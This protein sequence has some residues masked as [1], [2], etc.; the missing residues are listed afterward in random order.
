VK[1]PGLLRQWRSSDL[2]EPEVPRSANGSTAIERWRALPRAQRPPWPDRAE[3]DKVMRLLDSVPPIV[4]PAE[5]DLLR[6]QLGLVAEGRALVVRGGDRTESFATNTEA[7][8]VANAGALAQLA[9]PLAH[10]G[11]GPVV[12]VARVAGLYARSVASAVDPVGLPAYRGDLIN[13]AEPT[14]AARVADPHRMIQAYAHASG[15]TNIL[16]VHLATGLANPYALQRKSNELLDAMD[17]GW[18]YEETAMEIN[19]AMIF[20]QAYGISTEK[21]T[22]TPPTL[23]ISHEAL[24]LEYE[25]PLVRVTRGRAYDLSA[26]FLWLGEDIAQLE[27]AHVDFLSRIANPVGV[28]LGPT[29]GP[30]YVLDLCDKLNPDNTAGRLTLIC[31]MSGDE[32]RELL[33]PIIEKVTAA[34]YRVVWQCDPMRGADA[35]MGGS[36]GAFDRIADAVAAHFIVHR[37]LDTSAGGL[38]VELDGDG[39]GPAANHDP[40]LGPQQSLELALLVADM[41]RET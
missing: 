17:A 11:P 39:D 14:P 15:A 30:Q 27:G 18:Q 19:R 20:M 10:C 25:R 6:R 28:V 26:H 41:L 1:P 13:A 22:R 32:T 23:Y 8:L 37:S 36:A 24:A 38:Q 33:P 21:A 40:Q 35:D 9:I 31:R 5:V 4:T 7:H 34:G 16:R 3:V 2:P 12:T 29:V